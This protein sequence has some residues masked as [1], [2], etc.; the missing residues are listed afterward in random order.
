MIF[1]FSNYKDY[2][3]AFLKALP[4]QGR[5]YLSQMAKALNITSS[6]MSHVYKGPRDL[7]LEQALKLAQF[8]GLNQL[9]SEFFLE[10]VLLARAGTKDLQNFHEKKLAQLRNQALKIQNQVVND[11]RV[12]DEKQSAIFYSTWL[13]SAVR[14]FCSIKTSSLEEISDFFAIRKSRILPVLHFLCDTGLCVKRD[15]GFYIGQQSTFLPRESPL[16]YKHHSN[17]RLKAI[18]QLESDLD[19][20]I[21]YTSPVSMSQKDFEAFKLRLSTL[22]KE[23]SQIVQGSPP[24]AIACFNIDFF[25]LSAR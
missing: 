22:I 21:F 20:N 16:T 13:Y 9:E 10:L 1:N 24:E 17:W 5:G 12:L 19:T 7:T 11:H 15:G 6:Q 3:R 23:F 14:M 18:E 2:F 25:R 8:L 4:N